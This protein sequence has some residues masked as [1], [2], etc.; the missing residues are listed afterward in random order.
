[1]RSS[2]S[3]SSRL[4]CA[5]RPLS[6]WTSLARQHC[7]QES[8]WTSQGVMPSPS[9]GRLRRGSRAAQTVDYVTRRDARPHSHRADQIRARPD[10]VRS[11]RMPTRTRRGPVVEQRPRSSPSAPRAART[12]CY[13]PAGTDPRRGRGRCA[14]LLPFGRTC[15]LSGAVTIYKPLPLVVGQGQGDLRRLRQPIKHSVW[16]AVTSPP[17]AGQEARPGLRADADAAGRWSTAPA[18]WMRFGAS[19]RADEGSPPFD[20]SAPSR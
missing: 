7:W 20:D 5:H 1:M 19:R 15:L 6:S 10:G 11:V 17:T 12:N 8:R 2:R 18:R 13:W 4:P 3:R 9:A 14:S 16:T